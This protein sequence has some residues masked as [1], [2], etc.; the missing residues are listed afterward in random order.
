MR[1][2]TDLFRQLDTTTRTSDKV[3][4]LARYFREAPE[5]DRV[6]TIALLSHRRPR[7]T[8]NS[9]LLREWAA[10]RS[11]IPQWLFEESYHVVGDLAETI[12]LLLPQPSQGSDKS[13][14][15]WIELLM[16][17]RDS[18]EEEKKAAIFDAWDTLDKNGR[19]LFNKLITGGFRMGV[20]QRLMTKALSEATGIPDTSLAHRLMGNWDPV[21][22]SFEELVREGTVS[23]DIGKPYPFFLA[24][25]LEDEPDALGD[26]S[27]WICEWKW[28]GIRGQ[29]IRRSAESFIWSRGEELITE[30]F[31]DIAASLDHFPDG[32][33]ADGEI[34]VMRDDGVGPFQ[35]LQKRVGRKK[36]GP[37]VLRE[38]PAAFIAYDLL[39]WQGR[40]IR[41]LPLEKRKEYLMELAG[42]VAAKTPAIYFSDALPVKTWDDARQLR[43]EARTYRAE[44][45]M[46]KHRDAPYLT[47]RKK[48]G[49][50]KWKLDPFTIDAVMIYAM[51]GHGRRANLYTDFTFAVWDGDRLVPFT[52]AYS[53]L[54]DQEFN[55]ITRWVNQHTIERFGPVRSVKAELV[56]ELAFEGIQASSRHKSGIAL[57][58]PRISRWRHDKSAGEADRLSDLKKLLEAYGTQ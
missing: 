30:Q 53:G 10:E 19:F 18:S 49:W 25:P 5:K 39:E 4:A 40:D 38:Y 36:P 51:R 42:T 8:V 27:E 57:R 12:A 45:F 52:K 9:R 50:W 14:S 32:T 26:I 48:G 46:L 23:E 47:G 54:T 24:Y 7:R 17:M 34:V 58:F 29:M 33:V 2:F 16:S 55:E 22:I 28:D 56:F 11:G 37:K 6:W 21:T 35:D 44:G 3:R 20:S 15:D 41:D 1:H 13:L 43:S 31:P